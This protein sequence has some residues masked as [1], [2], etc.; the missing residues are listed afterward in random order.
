MVHRPLPGVGNELVLALSL[1]GKGDD[2][3]EDHR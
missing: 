3:H 1:S 2:G